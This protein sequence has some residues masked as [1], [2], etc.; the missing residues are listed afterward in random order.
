MENPRVGRLTVPISFSFAQVC[1]D[2][3]ISY[4]N[5]GSALTLFRKAKIFLNHL[6][7]GP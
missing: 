4:M 1:E 7:S 5:V 2:T 6:K 3:G